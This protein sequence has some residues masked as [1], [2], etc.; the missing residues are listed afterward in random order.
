MSKHRPFPTG[1]P[2]EE[3]TPLT[4]QTV[5]LAAWCACAPLSPK[6]AAEWADAALKEFVDRWPDVQ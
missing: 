3:P 2:T 4:R 5:W 1:Q 6:R